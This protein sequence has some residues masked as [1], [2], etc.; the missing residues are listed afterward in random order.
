[1]VVPI[2]AQALQSHATL[3]RDSEATAAIRADRD[4]F[5]YIRLLP[6]NYYTDDTNLALAA[7]TFGMHAATAS[8]CD[9]AVL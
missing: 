1:M 9:N 2:T 3:L 4:P 7:P 6:Q 8:S 5:H